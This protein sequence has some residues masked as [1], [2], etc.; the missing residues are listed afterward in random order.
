M[1]RLLIPSLMTG[2]LWLLAAL[3]LVIGRKF[4]RDSP[5]MYSFFGIGDWMYPMSYNVLTIGCVILSV[6]CFALTAWIIKRAT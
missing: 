3:L 4:A 1:Q 6:G 5:T 2:N